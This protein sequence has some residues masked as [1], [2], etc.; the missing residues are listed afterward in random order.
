[1]RNSTDSV[2]KLDVWLARNAP[3]SPYRYLERYCE[4]KRYEAYKRHY[5]RG[6]IDGADEIVQ[7]GRPDRPVAVGFVQ[8]M[9]WET[10]VFGLNCYR[11]EIDFYRDAAGLRKLTD[12]LEEA[13]RKRSGKYLMVRINGADLQLLQHLE[14]RGYVTIDSIC[15]FCGRPAAILDGYR[16]PAGLEIDRCEEKDLA[17][18]MEIARSSFT[19][20][21]FHADPL[22]P[23]RLASEA[24]ALWVRNAFAGRVKGDLLVARQGRR[25]GGFILTAGDDDFRKAAGVMIRQIILIA[26]SPRARGKGIGMALVFEAVC[27]ARESRADYLLVGTQGRNIQ[28]CRLYIGCGFNIVNVETTVRKGL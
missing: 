28:A 18:T 22:L 27:R 25:V 2:R 20:D 8:A 6:R 3:F 24:H 17:D 14:Q 1:M 5:Y 23:R 4:V 16:S 12:R 26:T 15:T 7:V 21:R 13:V 9:K 11:G 10:G 19:Q